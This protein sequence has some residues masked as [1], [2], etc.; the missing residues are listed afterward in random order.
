MDRI[1]GSARSGTLMQDG[2]QRRNSVVA[3]FNVTD[4]VLDEIPQKMLEA[5]IPGFGMAR[6]VL[7][8]LTGIDITTLVSMALLLT[9]VWGAWQYVWN[10]LV[11]LF[12]RYFAST[13]SITSNDK[14]FEQVMYWQS[15]HSLVAGARS[16][17]AKT[18]KRNEDIAQVVG[19]T[20]SQR[21]YNFGEIESSVPPQYV[22]S[23]GRHVFWFQRRPLFFSLE[24]P[25][26]VGGVMMMMN[27]GSDRDEPQ[28]I[29]LSCLGRSPAL[30]K[31]FL[32]TCKRFDAETSR[33]KT[34]IRRSGP[35]SNANWQRSLERPS[36]PLHTVYMDDAVKREL[37]RDVAEFIDPAT[38][39][40]Y[41]RRGIPHR[42]GLL[43]WGPPGTGKTSMAF[44][45]AGHFGF[46]LY[47]AGLSEPF[48]SEAKLTEL[49]ARLPARCI[50]LLED[51][52][53]AGLQ[54]RDLKDLT[55]ASTTASST[56][57]KENNDASK[58][59]EDAQQPKVRIREDT[60]QILP[61]ATVTTKVAEGITLAGLLNAIDGVASQEGRIL[62]MTSND[63]EKLDTA[64]VR[65]GRIDM[66]VHFGRASRRNVRA[67]FAT[68]F[69]PG[70][71]EALTEDAVDA[72]A[73]VA[74]PVSSSSPAGPPASKDML[75]DH[76]DEDKGG[77]AVPNGATTFKRFAAKFQPAEVDA[78]ATQ[79]AEILP[80]AA[81][82]PAEIQGFLL[83]RRKDP[84]KA[85]ADAP[86]WRDSVLES[87][88]LE[89]N[90][91][92]TAVGS[93]S[94]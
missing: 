71:D 1:F 39:R 50:I 54:K 78:M 44:A 81:F 22:P 42:R 51:V 83:T 77:D 43:F 93:G 65:P 57:N 41:A 31:E 79:F 56:N 34:T 14:L 15:R 89:R 21:R 18:S 28:N 80:D 4:D 33:F 72:V 87:R 58:P 27:S 17:K 66:Q 10:R 63:P 23:F 61:G 7:E 70:D 24:Q 26:P 94:A 13:I 46:D 60:R 90:I 91:V 38:P 85:L 75:D 37:L 69:T 6:I 32:M 52:D 40:F 30:I 20:R 82:T 74:S 47:V 2:G 53:S 68:M 59:A 35:T 76:L 86:G 12:F 92:R 25:K 48:M 49:F 55:K 9:A 5:F 19:A 45:L 3:G 64:L 11:G 84:R 62:I 67:I 8:A 16:L 88:E 73:S 29:V 36:R